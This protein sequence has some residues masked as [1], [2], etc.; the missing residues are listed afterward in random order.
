MAATC[1]LILRGTSIL[2]LIAGNARMAT[3]GEG[4]IMEHSLID[5]FFAFWSFSEDNSIQGGHA[6]NR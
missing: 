3:L 4:I 2:M 6:G 1:S 5:I